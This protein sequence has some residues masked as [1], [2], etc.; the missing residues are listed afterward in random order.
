MKIVIPMTGIGNRFVQG[1][2]KT[3]KPLIKIHEKTMIEWVIRLFPNESDF[4]F[5]CREDHLKTTNLKAILK[6]DFFKLE[7][8]IN[9]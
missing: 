6:K 7:A 5:I 4:I 9:I 2:Y 1:G 3:L 8:V